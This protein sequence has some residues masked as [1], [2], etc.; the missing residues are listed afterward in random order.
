MADLIYYKYFRLENSSF[1][2]AKRIKKL[3]FHLQLKTHFPSVDQVAKKTLS[4]STLMKNNLLN[5]K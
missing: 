5:L 4:I 3:F 2:Q 1:Q